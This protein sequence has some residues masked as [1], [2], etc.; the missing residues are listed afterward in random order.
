VT[1]SKS[2]A[3]FIA[4]CVITGVV[5]GV[6]VL[7]EP[8]SIA[9]A[10]SMSLLKEGNE[11]FVEMKLTYPNLTADRREAVASGDQKPLASVLACSDSRVP[12][13]QIVEW[14]D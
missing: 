8:R 5:A 2:V 6:F 13:E 3:I 12:V 4:L 14:I 11:R 1:K 9:A 7:G 10:D